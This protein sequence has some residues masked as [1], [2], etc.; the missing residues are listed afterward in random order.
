MMYCTVGGAVFNAWCAGHLP[1][2][3]GGQIG[4]MS[5]R[6]GMTTAIPSPLESALIARI[7]RRDYIADELRD[8]FLPN[9]TLQRSHFYELARER[10]TAP[11]NHG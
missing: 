6:L 11:E 8:A 1:A 7:N 2:A 10:L 9:Q 5:R 3:C 4:R